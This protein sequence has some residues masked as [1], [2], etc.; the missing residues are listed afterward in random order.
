LISEPLRDYYTGVAQKRN[1]SD[2]AGLRKEILTACRILDGEGLVK[3]F[4]HVSARVPGTEGRIFIT[5]RMALR[6]VKRPGDIALVDLQ[7]RVVEGQAE[8]PLE[9]H[10]H[11]AVYRRRPEVKAIC[12]THSPY[13]YIFGILERPLRAIHG[14]G[15][16]LGETVP[17][18]SSPH[19][20]TTSELAKE[21]AQSLGGGDALIVRG[22]GSITIGKSVHEAVVKSLFLEESAQLLYRAL[23]VGEPVYITGEDIKRRALADDQEYIRAWNYYKS[24]LP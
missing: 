4:G 20:I 12:R 7:G 3:G 10:L 16:L 9:F 15:A 6:L 13:T 18:Y 21:A 8:P 17:V 2:L 24:K 19:L 5:P 11:L 1:F 23:Q 14:W 22:N